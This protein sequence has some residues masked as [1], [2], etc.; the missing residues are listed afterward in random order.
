MLLVAIV[1]T[2]AVLLSA[3]SGSAVEQAREQRSYALLAQA[4]EALIGFAAT[5]GRL[6]RPAHRSPVGHVEGGA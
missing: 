2:A 3:F 1:A 5:H 4:S 6:P